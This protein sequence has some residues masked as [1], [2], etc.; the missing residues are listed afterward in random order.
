VKKIFICMT[1]ISFFLSAAH[2]SLI[3]ECSK[4]D[5]DLA[6]VVKMVESG[7]NIR[8][9]YRYDYSTP[10]SMACK[11]GRLDIVKYL[12]SKGALDD[13]GFIIALNQSVDS[14]KN[15]IVQFLLDQKKVPAKD[16]YEVLR[17]A[18]NAGNLDIF[19]SLIES[20]MDISV[21]KGDEPEILAYAISCKKNEF[22]RYLLEKGASAN[23]ESGNGLSLLIE[24][25]RNDDAADVSLLIEYKAIVSK[26]DKKGRTA[27]TYAL[28]HGNREII[29]MLVKKGA[30]INNEESDALYSAVESKNIEYTRF[31]LDLGADPNK[32][33]SLRKTPLMQ[34]ATSGSLKILQLLVS[35][36]AHLDDQYDS[37]TALIYALDNRR[38][39]C[40]AYL[41]SQGADLNAIDANR[42]SPLKWAIERNLFDVARIMIQKG[43]DVNDCEL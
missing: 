5:A 39:E 13:R 28:E 27:L 12:V 4:P 26:T 35:A 40:A 30:D 1:I 11:N 18:I 6:V 3:E 22:A 33:N 32:K 23:S 20:G 37:R 43:A 15:E 36:G 25:V 2:A 34:S 7:E 31:L 42:Q 14:K 24:A 10:L 21:R 41:V 17:T 16:Q 9:I 29:A 38:E 8:Q 19:K